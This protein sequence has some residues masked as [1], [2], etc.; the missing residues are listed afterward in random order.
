MKT[1][2]IIFPDFQMPTTKAKE[3]WERWL[4]TFV[5]TARNTSTGRLREYLFRSP[6]KD[7]AYLY[8]R[9]PELQVEKARITILEYLKTGKRR[10]FSPY[11]ILEGHILP[12]NIEMVITLEVDGK[13]L[14]LPIGGIGSRCLPKDIQRNISVPKDCT[15]VCF[16]KARM[17][18]VCVKQKL[19]E[20]NGQAN[21][22]FTINNKYVITDNDQNQLK[23]LHILTNNSQGIAESHLYQEK[24]LRR[25]TEWM[26]Q[27]RNREMETYVQ[28]SG[29]P[30][31]LH[32]M[33]VYNHWKQHRITREEFSLGSTDWKLQVL[34]FYLEA[35]NLL[36][37]AASTPNSAHLGM[38]AMEIL[39]KT[40]EIEAERTYLYAT[41]PVVLI[42]DDAEA[43]NIK[44][45]RRSN[46]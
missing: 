37:F 31:M 18:W 5:E 42:L 44:K 16:P 30:S 14:A 28:L 3:P 4:E 10:R 24:A 23:T 25:H 19:R 29:M 22:L 32:P 40:K 46:S 33:A 8:G 39:E 38:S 34:Q 13:H 7:G 27:L 17:P 11:I 2:Q 35:E 6:G 21:I 45:R 36:I 43:P 12:E 9:I 41:V 26:A 15:L 20:I 1:L